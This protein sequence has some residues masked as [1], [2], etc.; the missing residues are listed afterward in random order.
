MIPKGGRVERRLS[1]TVHARMASLDRPW[2]AELAMTENVSPFGARTLVKDAWK[3]GERVIV[4]SPGGRKFM[5]GTRCL[6]RAFEDR[7]NG[8]WVAV[9]R[10]ESRLDEPTWADRITAHELVKL[11]C[12]KE[13]SFIGGP[14]QR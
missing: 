12:L 7:R 13:M 4:E 10:T 9:G 14:A 8:G 2:L 6:L 1:V 3:P 11:G 5:R